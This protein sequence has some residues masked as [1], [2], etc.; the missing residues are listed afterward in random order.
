MLA[1]PIRH[2]GADLLW[3]LLAGLLGFL[4]APLLWHLL[5]HR[6]VLVVALLHLATL[7]LGYR[8]ALLLGHL[9]ALLGGVLE[10]LGAILLGR[11]GVGAFL[12]H[13]GVGGGA[14]LLIGGAALGPILTH[15]A[16]G[17]MTKKRNMN[18]HT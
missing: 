18:E 9:A 15:L 6:P 2:L 12:T 5:A 14:L 16:G 8:G 3:H 11:G 17:S 10:G 1:L 7:L 13:S 4:P